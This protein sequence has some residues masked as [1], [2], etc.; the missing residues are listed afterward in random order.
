MGENE[1]AKELQKTY[2]WNLVLKSLCEKPSDLEKILKE[3][4]VNI[5][6]WLELGKAQEE[7]TE[8]HTEQAR[9]KK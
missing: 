9:K 1:R 4:F 6:T 8:I 5:L 7:I 3:D 2:G